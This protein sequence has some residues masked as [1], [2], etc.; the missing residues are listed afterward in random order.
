M[1]VAEEPQKAGWTCHHCGRTLQHE[2]VFFKHHCQ[3]KVRFE[4]L[5]TPMGQ[6][7]FA[8]FNEWMRA[9][10]RSPQSLETFSNSRYYTTFLKFANHVV[11]TKLPDPE[12]FIQLMCRH[13]N[14]DPALWSRDE[15]YSIYLKV[16]DKAVPPITQFL[17]TIDEL[18]SLATDH[19]VELKDVFQAI[20]PSALSDLIRRRKLTFWGLMASSRFKQYLLSLGSEEQTWVAD[21]LNVHA[22]SIRIGEE[23]ALF[24]EFGRAMIEEGL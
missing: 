2:K 6:A 20:G 15:I 23:T 13:G 4:E 1:P 14:D 22:A 17:R 9:K 16:Y 8:Y 24:R 18:K 5:R 12:A 21:A 10:K 19:H 11:K 7:A 3:E